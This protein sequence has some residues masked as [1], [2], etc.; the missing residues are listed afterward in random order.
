MDGGRF[1]AEA[2]FWFCQNSLSKVYMDVHFWRYFRFACINLPSKM[3]KGSTFFDST[4]LQANS[5]SLF[6]HAFLTIF[7]SFV[8][9]SQLKSLSLWE[10]CGSIKTVHPCTVLMPEFC[11]QN[12]VLFC[13]PRPPEAV[14]FTAFK[15]PH[16]L[17][18]KT[19]CFAVIF[20][21]FFFSADALLCRK[22]QIGYYWLFLCG[23]W[24]AHGLWNVLKSIFFTW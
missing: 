6:F 14:V 5:R 17:Y 15:N 23:K 4:A 7:R 13:L 11:K 12:S 21:R 16:R 1:H 9:F 10:K 18:E 22:L 2:I 8:V 20:S 3:Y 19:S 24:S